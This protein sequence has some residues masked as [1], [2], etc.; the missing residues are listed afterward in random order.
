VQ[1]TFREPRVFDTAADAYLTGT[2]EQQIRSSFNFARQSAG[3]VVARRVTRNVSVTGSYQLQHTRVFDIALNINPFDVLSIYRLFPQVRLSSFSSSVIRDTRDDQVDPHTGGYLSANGQVAARAIGSEVGFA[4]TFVTAQYFHPV[5]SVPRI[6]FA[7]SARLGL[8]RGFERS[9]VDTSGN[10][11]Q[12]KDLP[13]SERFFAGGDTTVRGFALDRLGVQ[14]VPIQPEDTLDQDGFPLGGNG[15]IVFNGELRTPL[16]WGLSAVTFVDSG[17]VFA[18]PSDFDLSELRGSVG[19][20]I[21]W[22][23]PIGPFRID[24]GFKT[25]RNVLPG[26]IESRGQL[27]ISFGQAF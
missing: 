14:H 3:A 27:W 25:H 1:A 24:Y 21:R 4:K 17:Q 2:L 12:I 7:G 19:V 18:T 8:A 23:S 6:V 20:G 15:L 10:V 26:G 13:I 16:G 22:K 9:I 5:P 11:E